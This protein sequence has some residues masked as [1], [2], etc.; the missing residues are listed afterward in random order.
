MAN[1][2]AMLGRC[3]T[4]QM[5][6]QVWRDLSTEQQAELQP[7]VPDSVMPTSTAAVPPTDHGIDGAREPDY[8][9][10]P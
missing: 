9:A 3:M 1:A 5:P 6:Q 10:L 7:K 2:I 8:E 4:R